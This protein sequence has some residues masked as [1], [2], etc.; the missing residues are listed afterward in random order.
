MNPVC[1]LQPAQAGFASRSPRV[2]PPGGEA[3]SGISMQQPSAW[4]V[5]SAVLLKMTIAW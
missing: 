2:Q 4:T 3:Q 1:P 5:A